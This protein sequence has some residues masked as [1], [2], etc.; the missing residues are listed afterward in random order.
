MDIFQSKDIKGIIF[1]MDGVLVDSEPVMFKAAIAALKEF[2]VNAKP[3]DFVPFVGTGERSFLGNVSIKYGREY[4]DAMK[5]LAY[6][7]YCGIV[8]DE[9][10]LF[11]NTKEI[12]EQLKRKGYKLSV[13][14]GAD[15]IKVNANLKAAHL[16]FNL[17]DCVITGSDIT[18]SKPDPEIFLTAAN[19]M[20]L[21]PENC[22]VVEDAV[23]GIKGATAGGMK[24]LG[25]TSS[26][27]SDTL[28]SVGATIT[29][30][31]IGAL[32]NM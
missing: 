5:D 24:S 25:I 18:K 9:I 13:A 2:G 7:I 28:K 27:D 12:L 21:K 16:P 10:V 26:F 4:E 32:L 8:E 19:R 22:I 14:S 6:E 29:A 20:G 11:D 3:E 31:N 23:S 15:R 30:E 17:F 1:D